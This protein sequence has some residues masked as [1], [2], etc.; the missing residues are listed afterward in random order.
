M[1]HLTLL[2]VALLIL[3]LLGSDSPKEYNDRTVQENDIQ[4]TWRSD[5][6]VLRFRAGKLF[7]LDGY[8]LPRDYT[9]DTTCKPAHLDVA[10]GSGQIKFIYQIKGDLLEIAFRPTGQRPKSFDDA[11]VR[12]FTYKRV[13]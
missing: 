5:G 11:D 8:S 3:P 12:V 13:K 6:A 7:T 4:G 1:R 9:T 2:F 10:N